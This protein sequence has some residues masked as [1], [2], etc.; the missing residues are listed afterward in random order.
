M[1]M[2]SGVITQEMA[3]AASVGARALYHGALEPT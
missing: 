2:V 3:I 1:K